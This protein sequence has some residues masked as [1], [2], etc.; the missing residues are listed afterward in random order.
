M[1]AKRLWWLSFADPNLPRGMQFLG[2]CVVYG[3]DVATAARSAHI[4]GCNPGG[5]VCGWEIPKSLADAIP[6]KWRERLMQVSDIER[7]DREMGGEGRAIRPLEDKA[8]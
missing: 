4:A 6:L 5:E 2:A 7:M 1:I 3:F 8:S